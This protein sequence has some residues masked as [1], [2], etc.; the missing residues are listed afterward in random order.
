MSIEAKEKSIER[1]E[2]YYRL[3][4]KKGEYSFTHEQAI[5]CAINEV[6]ELIIYSDEWDDSEFHKKVLIELLKL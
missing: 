1:Y 3:L 6:N 4:S 5:Q 2:S